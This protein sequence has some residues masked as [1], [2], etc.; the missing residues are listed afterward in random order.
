VEVTGAFTITGLDD[1]SHPPVVGSGT[2]R[3]VVRKPRTEPDDVPGHDG[4]A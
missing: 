1:V 3:P 2:L 4:G